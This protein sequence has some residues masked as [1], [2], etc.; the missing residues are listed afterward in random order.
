MES[1][2]D[3][4]MHDDFFCRGIFRRPFLI[5]LAGPALMRARGNLSL[6][7]RNCFAM[8]NLSGA[9][10]RFERGGP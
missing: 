2:C 5:R 7:I 6:T 10:R 4:H 8:N 9:I 3:I 1:I